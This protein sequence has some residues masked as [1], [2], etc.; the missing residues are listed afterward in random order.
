MGTEKWNA[1]PDEHMIEY[2]VS[3]L[4]QYSII[5]HNVSLKY[6]ILCKMCE[7]RDS[8]GFD[9]LPFLTNPFNQMHKFQTLVP[10]V[11][12]YPEFIYRIILFNSSHSMTRLIDLFKSLFRRWFKSWFNDNVGQFESD[13]GKIRIISAG[14]W[15]RVCESLH[16]SCVAAS[17]A[18]SMSQSSAERVPAGAIVYNCLQL[19]AGSLAHWSCSSQGVKPTTCK[20][21]SMGTA[22]VSAFFLPEDGAHSCILLGDG[23]SEGEC[24]APSSGLLLLI[25]DN[26]SA[27]RKP[28]HASLAIH[29]AQ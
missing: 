26:I 28:A 4:E 5:L 2:F 13:A 1:W 19:K 21:K 3:T 18:S 7:V 29:L 6:H 24:N 22:S 23:E 14:D 16:V 10:L 15:Q 20:D 27:W 12:N 25:A 8:A 11:R 17:V 9:T